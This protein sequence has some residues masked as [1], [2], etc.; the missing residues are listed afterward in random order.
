[1]KE[2]FFWGYD[3]DGEEIP[4][5]WG[6]IYRDACRAGIW[7][8]PIPRNVLLRW[9]RVWWMR[10]RFGKWDAE[11]FQLRQQVWA[12]LKEKEWLTT[13][14]QLLRDRPPLE[15]YTSSTLKTE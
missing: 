6:I 5:F 9:L 7:L 14:N 8:A 4:K 1:M 11:N 10:I 13:Q 2:R 12:L 15:S 3:R